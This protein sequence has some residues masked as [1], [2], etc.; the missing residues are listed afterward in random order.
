MSQTTP[1]SAAPA[2][3]FKSAATPANDP[4]SVQPR[5]RLLP[6][7]ATLA[8][9]ATATAAVTLLWQ[10]YVGRPW[11]RDGT[12]RAYVVT[13]AP[14]VPGE[15]TELTVKDNQFVRKGDL[16][17]KIDPRDYQVAVDFNK[18]ALD[19]AQAD[20]ENKKAEA[21]RRLKLSDLGTTPEEQQT[22]VAS[23][24]IA[25]ATIG[26]QRANLRRAEINLE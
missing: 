26:Q 25:L 8:V 3:A 17:M 22:Y 24:N 9:A 5:L 11:T 10:T 1:S 7:L 21:A 16:L 23:A 12:V 18:A 6:I 15:V 4:R 19:Q 14:E 13:L 2:Q 20:Y